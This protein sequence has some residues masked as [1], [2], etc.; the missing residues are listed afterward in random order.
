[1]SPAP[2]VRNKWPLATHAR[3][4]FSAWFQERG[5]RAIEKDYDDGDKFLKEQR[6][7]SP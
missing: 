4:R 3:L 6:I 5:E 1:M 2:T 7:L